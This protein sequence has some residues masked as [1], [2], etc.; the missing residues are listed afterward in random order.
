MNFIWTFWKYLFIFIVSIGIYLFYKII[1][2]VWLQRRKYSRYNNVYVNPTFVPFLGDLFNYIKSVNA[3]SVYYSHLFKNADTFGK[4]D[5]KLE[6]EGIIPV[7][8]IVSPE[9]HKQFKDL[10]PHK[11]DRYAEWKAFGKIGPDGF[12]NIRSSEKF[13]ERKKLFMN[14]LSLNS[15]S[16]YIPIIVECTKKSLDN[17]KV[18]DEFEWISK[19]NLLTFN[20]FT[21]IMF[22]KDVEQIVLLGA[23]YIKLF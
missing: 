18:N 11:I 13:I 5:L 6:M 9:A 1:I 17:I 12:F 2:K 21:Q 7:I 14:L 10:Q 4:Y 23:D 22:G 8:K 3:G 20:I 16:K 15:V 19:M